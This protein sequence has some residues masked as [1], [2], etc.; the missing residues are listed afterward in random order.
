MQGKFSTNLN[1]IE[2]YW[3][4]IENIKI[5]I[6]PRSINLRSTLYSYFFNSYLLLFHLL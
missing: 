3:V 1:Q 4:E 6:F 5:N 2:E